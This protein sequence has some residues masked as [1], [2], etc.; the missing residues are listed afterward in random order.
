M[1]Y[2][3]SLRVAR[4]D[5]GFSARKKLI[6]TVRDLPEDYLKANNGQAGQVVDRLGWLPDKRW[7][8]ALVS[9]FEPLIRPSG[10]SQN[11]SPKSNLE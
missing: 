4:C 1:L 10:K 11:R 9:D 6:F 3:D 8:A 2:I 7:N 5:R